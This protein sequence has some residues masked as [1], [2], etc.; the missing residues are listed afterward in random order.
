M[1]G[2]KGY[3]KCFEDWPTAY[4]GE[5][6]KRL[7]EIKTKYDLTDLFEFPQSIPSF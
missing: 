7:R 3:F 5:N 1:P 6:F 2:Y 4:Y